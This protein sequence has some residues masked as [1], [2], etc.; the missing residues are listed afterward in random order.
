M[1]LIIGIWG[2]D[3][4]VYAA[5]KFFLYT[6]LGSVLMLAAFLYLGLSSGSFNIETFYAA[7]LTMSAQ[8]FHLYCFLFRFLR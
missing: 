4:R 8:N 7:R 5:I 6:F 3:N 1:Y 2:S